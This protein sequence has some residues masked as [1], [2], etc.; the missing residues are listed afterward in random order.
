MYN[1]F[2]SNFKRRAFEKALAQIKKEGYYIELE[3]DSDAAAILPDI[4]SEI[5][6][7]NNTETVNKPRVEDRTL[8][9]EDIYNIETRKKPVANKQ[10]LTG[11]F[12]KQD[13]N[14]FYNNLFKDSS[15]FLSRKSTEDEELLS[16][17]TEESDD[18]RL[19]LLSRRTDA[20]IFE[21]LR[22][23]A[24]EQQKQKEEL[25]KAEKE[26]AQLL[27]AQT[28]AKLAEEEKLKAQKIAEEE[29]K[30][31]LDAELLAKQERE[32]AE[33]ARLAA[34]ATNKPKPKP[35][36]TTPR[37]RKRKYD[38]DIVGGFDF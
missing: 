5:A 6:S 25:E 9:I 34:L 38:A 3:D 13:K 23:R 2:S 17:K 29:R 24:E 7:L 8:D 36:T 15:T 35:K 12:V 33:E 14:L 19:K 32:R 37:K 1:F 16:T 11:E 21:Q 10:I 27:E 20:Q 31:R 30:A 22:K 26:R 18:D 4:S 28:K